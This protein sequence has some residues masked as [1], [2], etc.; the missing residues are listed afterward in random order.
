MP[1][2]SFMIYNLFHT[3]TIYSYLLLTRS[4]VNTLE[5]RIFR[6]FRYFLYFLL[7][8]AVLS[9]SIFSYKFYLFIPSSLHLIINV[10]TLLAILI[11]TKYSNKTSWLKAFLS[12]ILLTSFSILF[13]VL[14]LCTISI[15]EIDFES[16][17]TFIQYFASLFYAL[18][19]FSF[20]FIIDYYRKQQQKN[21]SENIEITRITVSNLNYNSYFFIGILFFLYIF[22]QAHIYWLAHKKVL[23]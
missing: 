19:C 18:L 11:F 4:L 3:I 22:Y 7:L 10:S 21:K 9:F 17:Y 13:E 5:L 23:A 2:I 8:S 6:K 15:L 16:I 14:F 12:I 20:A 1:I